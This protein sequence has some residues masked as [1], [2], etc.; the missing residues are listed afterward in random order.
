MYIHFPRCDTRLE[1]RRGNLEAMHASCH[2]AP[3]CAATAKTRAYCRASTAASSCGE[4]HKTGGP[5][6]HGRL[7]VVAATAFGSAKAGGTATN[8]RKA[9]QRRNGQKMVGVG[10]W[11]ALRRGVLQVSVVLH[12]WQDRGGL[13]GVRKR[14]SLCE[15]SQGQPGGPSSAV[16]SA[17]RP[18]SRAGRRVPFAVPRY[19]RSPRPPLEEVPVRR[20]FHVRRGLSILAGRNQEEKSAGHAPEG[21]RGIAPAEVFARWQVECLLGVLGIWGWGLQETRLLSCVLLGLQLRLVLL[22]FF[23]QS[24]ELASANGRMPEG[25]PTASVHVRLEDVG[26]PIEYPF[27]PLHCPHTTSSCLATVVVCCCFATA[28]HNSRCRCCAG[29]FCIPGQAICDNWVCLPL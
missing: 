7:G 22:L 8:Q 14:R 29:T 1:S 9:Y 11:G 21:R 12:P 6:L 3:C 13:D 26:A 15:L 27:E 5:L 25:C 28:Q 19:R 2:R 18:G 4:T 17:P 24:Q 10:A 20:R 16:S 23:C